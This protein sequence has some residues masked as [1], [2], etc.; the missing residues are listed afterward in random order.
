MPTI[1]AICHG[2]VGANRT[3]ESLWE[4][5]WIS[6]KV[7]PVDRCTAGTTSLKWPKYAG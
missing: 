6:W 2:A 4:D 1:K 3:C 5:V 7:K